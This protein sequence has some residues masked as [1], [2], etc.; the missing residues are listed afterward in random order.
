MPSFKELERGHRTA[1]DKYRGRDKAALS[2]LE[3]VAI[4]SGDHK[5][6]RVI[7]L[8]RCTGPLGQLDLAK[9]AGLK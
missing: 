1:A 5:E 9:Y 6:A 3:A 7:R 2:L 4:A 8:A